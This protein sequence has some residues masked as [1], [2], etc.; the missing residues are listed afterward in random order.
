MKKLKMLLLLHVLFLSILAFGI[1][2]ATTIVYSVDDIDNSS[3]GGDLWQ[4]SYVVS[5]YSF[6][7]D[8]GFTIFFDPGLYGSLDPAPVSPN[9]EWDVITWN[10]DTAIPDDG[11]FDALALADGASLDDAFTVRFIWSGSG[12]PGSQS[13]EVYDSNY[14]PIETGTT[15][16]ATAPVPEPATMLLFVTG[17]VGLAGFRKWILKA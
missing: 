2:N 14:N 3:S 10:P 15:I 8:F 17:I 16:A 5:D 7:S 1:C 12:N 6:D 13:F 4:Y 11:A 9:S